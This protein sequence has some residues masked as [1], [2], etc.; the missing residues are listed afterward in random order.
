MCKCCSNRANFKI[1]KN[2]CCSGGSSGTTSKKS[3]S[4]ALD[5]GTFLVYYNDYPSPDIDIESHGAKT[6]VYS[7]DLYD[8]YSNRR[9]VFSAD[10]FNLSNP[11]GLPFSYQPIGVRIRA[12]Y[13]N[14]N[15]YSDLLNTTFNS[16]GIYNFNFTKPTG[17]CVLF[18][19]FKYSD[20]YPHPPPNVDLCTEIHGARIDFYNS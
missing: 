10:I 12:F 4:V 14:L 19:D 15:T 6:I 17:E 9:I 13:P 16:T 18:V 1:Y 3:E 2:T 7:P 8:V 5:G 11:S 20:V